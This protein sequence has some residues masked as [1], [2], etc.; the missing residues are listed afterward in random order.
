MKYYLIAGEASGDLHGS[1][2]MKALAECDPQ[3]DFRFF[4]GDLMSASGGAC[5]RHYKNLAYMGFWPVLTHLGTILRS[6]RECL[7]DI[8]DWHP[9]AVILIDYP[10]FN[11]SIAR[12][13]HKS[14]GIPVYYYI[15]PKLWA[16]KGYRIRS[17]RRYV[18]RL[19]SILPF[20]VEYFHNRNYEVDYVGNPCVDAVEA[21]HSS[22][23]N[24]AKALF[25]TD[26]EDFSKPVIALLA[27]SRRQ[28]INRNLPAMLQATQGLDDYE[29]VLAAAPGIN[30]D[31][32]AG[33]LQRCESGNT[34]RL[35]IVR[36]KTYTI[37]EKARAALVTS[38]TATLETALFRVP[39]VVCYKLPAHWIALLFKKFILKVKYVSLV[40]L[41]AGHEVVPELLGGDMN[42]DNVREHLLPLL[43]DTPAT[44]IRK[45]QLSGYDE[46]IA[47]LGP[48]GASR[49][50]ASAI[51]NLLAS[52]D[53]FS[54]KG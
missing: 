3:A 38:G 39:Q 16:W 18:D 50:V 46:V 9:D 20:E 2:L 17:I 26:E 13:V 52:S 33:V 24:D 54:V 1:N 23:K 35:H 12:N 32:Y 22:T 19:F 15:S 41:I 36:G 51:Y 42:A 40:N 21:Y 28:E 34:R 25:H 47:I 7:A 43:Q 31:F 30:D 48:A 6:G 14:L 53:S 5:V 49:N 8:A 37:L 10:G 4:G 27:G 29:L 44:A 11:L 45:N